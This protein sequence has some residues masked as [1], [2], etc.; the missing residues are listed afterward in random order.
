MFFKNISTGQSYISFLSLKKI[1]TRA[2]GLILGS[3][4]GFLKLKR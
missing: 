4:S 1:K 2:I 3:C